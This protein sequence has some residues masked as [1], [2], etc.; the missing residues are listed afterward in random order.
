MW[1]ECDTSNTSATQVQRRQHKDNESTT[2]VRHEQHKCDT[3][4]KFYFVNG[5]R[6]IPGFLS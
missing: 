6:D 1:Q 5:W 4:K 3:Q 2:L